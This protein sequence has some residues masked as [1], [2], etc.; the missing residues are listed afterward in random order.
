M[1]ESPAAVADAAA[2]AA[3]PGIDAL[4]AGPTDLAHA[5][6]RP[7][8]LADPALRAAIEQVAAAGKPA[9]LFARDPAEV[10]LARALGLRLIAAGS[11]VGF[12][13]RGAALS[14]G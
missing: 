6:G 3:V 14:R 4:F 5:L 9:G 11:D 2:I 13:L 12:L 8:D 10:A 7:R 1:V